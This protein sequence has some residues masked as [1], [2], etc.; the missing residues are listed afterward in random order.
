MTT[1]QQEEQLREEFYETQCEKEFGSDRLSVYENDAELIED[2][3]IT[4]IRKIEIDIWKEAEQILGSEMDKTELNTNLEFIACDDLAEKLNCSRTFLYDLKGGNR[5]LSYG[6]F[7][8]I[9]KL[10]N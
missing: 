4:K 1:N 9:K 5:S 6:F 2:W 10:T 7:K 3:W 8:K